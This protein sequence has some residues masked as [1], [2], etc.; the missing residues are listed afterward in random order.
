MKKVRGELTSS[1]PYRVRDELL[2]V[3]S[4]PA[5]IYPVIVCEGPVNNNYPKGMQIKNANLYIRDV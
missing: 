4:T 1:L 3:V 5:M 2:R